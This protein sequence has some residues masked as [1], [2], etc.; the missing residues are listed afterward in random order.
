MDQATPEPVSR[1]VPL[2]GQ[3]DLI[4]QYFTLR[5]IGAEIPSHL[6]A[7]ARLIE[8]LDTPL[9]QGASDALADVTVARLIRAGH[10]NQAGAT[11]LSPQDEEALDALILDRFDVSAVAPSLRERAARLEAIGSTLQDS[12]IVAPSYLTDRVMASIE[13][14][15]DARP[16]SIETARARRN[17]RVGD[18]VGV[19]AALLL[20][21]SVLWPMVSAARMDGIKTACLSNMRTVGGGMGMYANENRDSMPIATASLGGGR[22]WDV[23]LESGSNSRNLFTLARK[24]FVKV[25]DLACPGNPG[26]KDCHVT[27][28]CEDWRSLEEVSY[29]YQ[30]MLGG[31]RPAWARPGGNPSQTIV[32]ADRSPVVLKNARGQAVSPTE[33]SPNHQGMGQHALYSDGHVG[34]I[35]SPEVVV[36]SGNQAMVDNIWL[37]R[38]VEIMIRQIQLQMQGQSMTDPRSPLLRGTEM[39]TENDI[40]LGP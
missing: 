8:L 4:D 37:P 39:P 7:L 17:W 6:Q 23:G 30:I 20:G 35:N 2:N 34:W 3:G 12:Q 18:L 21:T 11:G 9:G 25:E 26:C 22:W 16:I 13:A 40:F 28:E 36:N 1:I 32:M 29:S 33:N 27:P 14:A 31:H 38:P 24:G 15:G 5:Q 10:D 19:A